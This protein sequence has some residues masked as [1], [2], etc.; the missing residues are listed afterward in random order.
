MILRQALRFLCLAWLAL[1]SACG[2]SDDSDVRPVQI[3]IVVEGPSGTHFRVEGIQTANA[4]HCFVYRGEDEPACGDDKAACRCQSGFETPFQFVLTNAAQ[5][6]D[7]NDP[8]RVDAEHPMRATFGVPPRDFDPA[9][10]TIT[11]RLFFGVEQRQVQQIVPGRC[12]TLPGV[13]DQLGNY[14]CNGSVCT[15]DEPGDSGGGTPVV[16]SP[17]VRF[18]LCHATQNGGPCK[19][20]APAGPP[21]IGFNISVGDFSATDTTNCA[22]T[23]SPE[24]CTTPAIVYFEGAADRVQGVF[25]NFGPSGTSLQADLFVN[26]A[27]VASDADG[28]TVIIDEEI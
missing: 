7:P 11:V 22:V 1:L 15:C 21:N 18:D 4:D 10:D 25:S 8:T 12:F 6:R 3:L 27:H 13:P 14:T 19:D 9:A 2:T 24:F 28:R 17:E 16:T 20:E 5:F 26:N 23:G